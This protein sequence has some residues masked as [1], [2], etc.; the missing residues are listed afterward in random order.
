MPLRQLWHSTAYKNINLVYW[1]SNLDE[2]PFNPY[3]ALIPSIISG[4][5]TWRYNDAAKTQVCGK[6]AWKA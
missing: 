6:T 2:P 3:T 1:M 4:K 5:Q